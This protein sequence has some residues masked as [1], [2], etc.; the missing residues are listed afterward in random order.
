MDTITPEHFAACDIRVCRVTAAEPLAG[1]HKPAIKLTLDC[2]PDLGTRHSS[3]QLTERYTPGQ[4]VGR[5]VLAVVN[6]PP[7]RIAGFKSEALVL[8]VYS[9]AGRGPVVLIAPDDDPA[10]APGDG[11]G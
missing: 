9:D 6:F 11:L 7:K 8:G 3:A 5:L 2:G 4:L 1:A 10:V